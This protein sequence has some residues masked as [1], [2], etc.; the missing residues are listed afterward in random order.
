MAIVIFLIT[1]PIKYGHSYLFNNFTYQL[2]NTNQ[3]FN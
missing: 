3:A 2:K 1:L